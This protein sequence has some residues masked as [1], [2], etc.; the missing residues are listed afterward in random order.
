MKP[1][2]VSESRADFLHKLGIT[3]KELRETRGWLYFMIVSR[4]MAE[5]RISALQSECCELSK[6]LARS[7]VTAKVNRTNNPQK[8]TAK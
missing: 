8:L 7:I 5:K 1:V 4:L 2:P 3:L 6:I